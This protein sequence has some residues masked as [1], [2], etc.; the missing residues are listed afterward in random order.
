MYFICWVRVLVGIL[1][2]VSINLP[3]CDSCW[4]IYSGGGCRADDFK[5]DSSFIRWRRSPRF[6][7]PLPN[8]FQFQQFGPGSW[9]SPEYFVSTGKILGISILI[10]SEICYWECSLNEHSQYYALK[11]TRTST[12]F[13]TRFWVSRVYHFTIKAS[14]KLIV[15]HEYDIYLVWYMEYMTRVECFYRSVMSYRTE[16]D[17]KLLRFELSGG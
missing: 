16:S 10:R 13:S 2:E 4:I 12:L 14:L 6:R 11:R 7:D 9:G 8:L 1:P 5:T 15:F 17:I 3:L